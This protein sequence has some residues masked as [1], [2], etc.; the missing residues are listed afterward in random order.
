[1]IKCSQTSQRI[2]VRWFSSR[3]VS[4]HTFV[5]NNSRRIINLI[6]IPNNIITN[7]IVDVLRHSRYHVFWTGNSNNYFI[8]SLIQSRQRAFYENNIYR[9]FIL[10]NP[11]NVFTVNTISTR[12][13]GWRSK[14]IFFF[15]FYLFLTGI[16]MY[17]IKTTAYVMTLHIN[18]YAEMFVCIYAC[19][20]RRQN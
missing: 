15:I 8:T 9:V 20:T 11:T 5:A 16:R 13:S 10:F 7:V 4:S 17:K 18:V 19:S 1:M 12:N 2:F 3:H 6:I 14:K